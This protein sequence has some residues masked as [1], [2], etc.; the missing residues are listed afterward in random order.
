[1]GTQTHTNKFYIAK[2]TV[3]VQARTF[4]SETI[5][6]RCEKLDPKTLTIN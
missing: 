6:S 2:I 4:F 1:M 3:E 5:A